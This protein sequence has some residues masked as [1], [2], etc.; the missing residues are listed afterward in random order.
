MTGSGSEKY[1]AD[2]YFWQFYFIRRRVFLP[3]FQNR[4]KAAGIAAYTCGSEEEL[5]M[6]KQVSIFAENKKGTMQTITGILEREQINI[7][8]SVTN[9]SAEYGIIRMV[10]SDTEKAMKALSEAGYLCRSTDVLGIQISDHPGALNTLL[11]SIQDSNI[12]VNYLYL[13][14]SRD[15]ASPIIILH[16]DDVMEVEECLVSRGFVSVSK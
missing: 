16:T 14:F 6:L 1:A 4:L 9:D 11:K 3:A 10:V 13:S 8:G 12:N 2:F 7:L 15:S 5:Y